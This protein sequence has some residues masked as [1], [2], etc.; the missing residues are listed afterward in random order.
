[1]K[2]P[3]GVWM[4]TS[5]NLYVA[6]TGDN[7]VRL[8]DLTTGYISTIAG[9]GT[10]GYSGDNGPAT[11]ALLNAP[12]GVAADASGNVYISDTGNNV[13][14]KVNATTGIIT[15]I[16]GTGQISYSGN[17]GLGTLATLSSP[18]GLAIDGDGN[19][20]IA[21]S[22]N[23]VIRKWIAA[24]GII[25]TAAG[26]GVS[27]YNGDYFAAPSAQL[28]APADVKVDGSGNIYIADT[29][30]H[31]IRMVANGTNMITTIA[32]TNNSGSTGDG[33]TAT[34][35]TLSAPKGLA[36]DSTGNLYISDSSNN[37]IRELIKSSAKIYLYAGTG[38][39]S[40]SGDKGSATSATFH[41]PI[42]ATIDSNGNLYIAD[43]VNNV[44]RKI[45][46]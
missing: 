46:Q 25:Q 40:Y 3:A 33:G 21:E 26:N 16:A 18:Q 39:A 38:T 10:G 13:V 4:T 35:A 20:L 34:D 8:V 9:T 36:L 43:S 42:G 1:M 14:R 32:G 17:G 15:T 12:A 28:D 44:I 11:Q 24:T 29:G 19:L 30:N 2:T 22:G 45:T 41:T 23:H 7:V 27:G 6:D 31:V 37:T 5:G